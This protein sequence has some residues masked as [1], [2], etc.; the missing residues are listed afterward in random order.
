M[1]INVKAGHNEKTI[2]RVKITLQEENILIKI[3]KK[4]LHIERTIYIEI[5][6]EITIYL[7]ENVIHV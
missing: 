6:I 5:V 4:F 3:I 7:F 2:E 1:T